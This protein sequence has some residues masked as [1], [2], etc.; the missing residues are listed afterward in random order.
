MDIITQKSK[1]DRMVNELF[2]ESSG[3]FDS[4]GRDKD[5]DLYVEQSYFGSLRV[6]FVVGESIKFGVGDTSW[7]DLGLPNFEIRIYT[8]ARMNLKSGAS[9][10]K[11]IVE[12]ASEQAIASSY[13]SIS[14]TKSATIWVRACLAADTIDATELRNAVMHV[15]RDAHRW[16]DA[17]LPF[18]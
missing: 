5:G 4:I 6:Y 15:I 17:A 12:F 18:G 10:N 3:V 13:A 16:R 1:I 9:L 11:K 8:K 14:D 2:D 7:D